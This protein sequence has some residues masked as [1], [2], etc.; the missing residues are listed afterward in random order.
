[1][2]LERKGDNMCA[3]ECKHLVDWEDFEVINSK[4]AVHD[5]FSYYESY[6]EFTSILDN[7]QTADLINRGWIESKDDLKSLVPLFQNIHRTNLAGF[8]RKTPS[9]D[10]SLCAFWQTRISSSAKLLVATE[11]VSPFQGLT[12]DYLRSIGRLSVDVA[13]VARLPK[14]LAE[15]G[16][17]LIYEKSLPAMKLDGV[18][19]SLESGH[20]VVGISFRYKR[21]DYFW[22]TLMHELAHIVLHYEALHEP[23]FDNIDEKSIEKIEMQ[24]NR[25]AKY[26]LVE[27]D[28]WRNCK[29]MYSNLEKDIF[30]FAE[31]NSVHPAIVAGFLQKE[32]NSYNLYRKIVDSVDLRGIIFGNE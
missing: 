24:A 2:N 10:K 27:K 28:K 11:R 32:T 20:P 31:N 3:L 22:F 5:Q 18:V 29:P 1:M 16:I 13:N 21:L 25:L 8:F 23:I 6:K 15:I 4:D 14:I 19:F 12:K 17:V 7:V 9:P 30:E 26:S